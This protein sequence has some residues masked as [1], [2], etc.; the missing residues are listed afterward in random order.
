MDCLCYTN[1][2]PRVC[3]WVCLLQQRQENCSEI[4]LILLWHC[5]SLQFPFK[6]Q[7][8]KRKW[9]DRLIDPLVC[10]LVSIPISLS[11]PLGKCS[12]SARKVLGKCSKATKKLS[13]LT[14]GSTLQSLWNCSEN[15]LKLLWNC[16]E[17]A[18]RCKMQDDRIPAC[19]L[20]RNYPETASKW[21]QKLLR[22]CPQ[23]APNL[24]LL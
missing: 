1:P 12:E 21:L 17:I 9:S 15:A 16:S 14:H 5:S 8:K 22:N 11:K 24:L 13:L 20:P 19:V 2:A 7:N 10:L 18:A 23:T 3:V 4:A 6:K